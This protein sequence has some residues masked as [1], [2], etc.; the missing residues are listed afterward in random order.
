MSVSDS[1]ERL[2][3]VREERRDKWR[4]PAVDRKAHK[5]GSY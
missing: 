2:L 4:R 1:K 3:M 5:Y